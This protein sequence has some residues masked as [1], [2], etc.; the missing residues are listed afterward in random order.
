MKFR[1]IAAALA[2]ASIVMSLSACQ[3]NIVPGSGQETSESV[4]DIAQ[5]VTAANTTATQIKTQI[6]TFLVNM[7]ATKCGMKMGDSFTSQLTIR[8][9]KGVWKVTNSTPD[10]FISGG[11]YT[12]SGSGSSDSTSEDIAEDELAKSLA[13]VLPD[14][15]TGGIAVWLEGGSCKAVSFTADSVYP[16]AQT[17]EMMGKGGWTADT[18]EWDGTTAG[19]SKDGNIVGTSPMLDIKG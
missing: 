15:T 10:S 5:Q 17:L 16:D 8:V 12:W 2:A 4:E 9:E 13:D 14:V 11:K 3:S 6:M 19:V 1:R 7:D 18:C